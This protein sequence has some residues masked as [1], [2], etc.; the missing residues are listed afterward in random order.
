MSN[1]PLS[2]RIGRIQESPTLAITAKAS[3]LKSE[4]KDII[5]LAAGEPD[6]DTPDFIK[7]AA[8]KAIQNGLTK[9]TP[10]T[11]LPSLKKAVASKLL[12]E[13]NLHYETNEIVVGVGGKQCIF[14]LCLSILN[15]GDEVIIPAPYWV[16][17][18][19]IT[20]LTGA[21]PV[22]VHC[23]IEQSFKIT[24]TQLK[25]A[26]SKKTKLVFLN[27]PSNPTGAVYSKTELRN[28]ANVLL[29]YPHIYIG[30][31]DIYEKINLNSEP[32]NNILMIEPKLKDR[33]IVLN[34]VSKAYSM[35]G[36]RIGY[37]A[38]PK[39]IITA[40]GILQ[41]QSTSNPTSISQAAAEAALNSDQSCI[42]PMLN[43]FKERHAFVV[44]TINEISGINCIPAQGAFYSFP[45]AREAIK[46]LHIAGKIKT[47]D[48]IAFS[49]YLLDTTGVAVV[50][51]SAFGAEGYF[52]LSFATS[53]E[54]LKEALTR[55]KQAIE[56]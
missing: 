56:I 43:A 33:C 37:A 11:G 30:T 51:G 29:K 25:A 36:W 45:D 53:M 27:S 8:I 48:D 44:D 31:D 1:S 22:I 6:F 34:G 5:G 39:N 26:I 12:R 13:N 32:F 14:N 50:P 16:S 21:K 10:V 28:I 2:Q 15:A 20:Q 47:E 55:I 54:N 23:G 24:P 40:M 38:G 42:I 17:Y 41:S 46:A 7:Q 18:A 35:T 3:R 9:Y 52:R 49:E 19:D 4:G